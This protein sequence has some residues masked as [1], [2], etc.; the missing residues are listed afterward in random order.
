MSSSTDRADASI[1]GSTLD[2]D[3]DN[4]LSF[5]DSDF[6][7]N[8]DDVD[9]GP[10]IGQGAFSKVYLGRYLGELVRKRLGRFIS[11]FIFPAALL[12]VWQPPCGLF[13]T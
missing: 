11:C 7:L 9:I 3:A 6:Y 13:L 1:L 4:Q 12:L 8:M 10:Q 2:G 5:N